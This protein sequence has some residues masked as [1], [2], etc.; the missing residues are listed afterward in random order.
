ML[1][2]ALWPLRGCAQSS[3]LGSRFGALV[4]RS[5]A[6]AKLRC[7]V[8]VILC[9]QVWALSTIVGVPVFTSI[10]SQHTIISASGTRTP[11]P[12]GA[13]VVVAGGGGGWLG[14]AMPCARLLKNK[15]NCIDAIQPQ[16][17]RT[18]GTV[19]MGPDVRHSRAP[20]LGCILRPGL[21][22]PSACAGY[23]INATWLAVLPALGCLAVLALND[24]LRDR[25]LRAAEPG[26]VRVRLPRGRVLVLVIARVRTLEIM[27]SA[28][29]VSR[30]RFLSRTAAFREAWFGVRRAT[31]YPPLLP[32]VPTS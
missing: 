2:M 30:A 7:V 4:R 24:D 9:V 29:R 21:L 20:Y 18:N 10:V 31:P 16:G 5:T 25:A 11:Q 23:A 13:F 22:L 14:G 17:H 15:G 26:T 3:G 1:R 6:V 12:E 28:R 19:T 27:C 8:A 32:P